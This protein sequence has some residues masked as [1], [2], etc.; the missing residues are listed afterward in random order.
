MLRCFLFTDFAFSA[1]LEGDVSFSAGEKIIFTKVPTNVGNS[2]DNE[3]GIFT[4]PHNGT[5]LF[6]VISMSTTGDHTALITVNGERLRPSYGFG[7][8]RPGK[9]VFYILYLID[10]TAFGSHP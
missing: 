9:L 4:A 1:E 2:Y 7:G 6:T 3:T 8:Y 10:M 5:Y